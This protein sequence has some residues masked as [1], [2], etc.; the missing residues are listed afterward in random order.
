MVTD[1]RSGQSNR[2]PVAEDANIAQIHAATD[3]SALECF[4][5]TCTS[6]TTPRSDYKY[7]LK[8]QSKNLLKQEKI[9]GRYDATLYETKRIRATAADGV[10]IPFSIVYRKSLFKH[11]GSSPILLYAYG[12]YGASSEHCFNAAVISLLDRGFIY[13]IAHIRRG[14]GMGRAWY[15]DGKLPKKKK[16][17]TDYISCAQ[18]LANEK[19]TAPERLFA[20]GAGA[21]SMLM[22]VITNLPGSFPKFA[23]PSAVDGCHHRRRMTVHSGMQIFQTSRLILYIDLAAPRRAISLIFMPKSIILSKL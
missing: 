22:G 13:G 21:G 20:H 10:K 18:Y 16:T 8:H 17:F 14:Q 1:R 12:S 6:L 5:F 3:A 4:R 11:D 19:Y 2:V 23:G 15:E 7:D 9:G